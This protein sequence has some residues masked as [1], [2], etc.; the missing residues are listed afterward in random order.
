MLPRQLAPIAEWFDRYVAGFYGQDPYV[1]A[2]LRYKE[3]HCRH[4]RALMLDLARQLDQQA[5]VQALAEAI[6]L[7]HDVGRFEQFATYRTYRDSQSVDH[8]ALG[9]EVLQ[10]HRVLAPLDPSEQD[11]AEAAIRLHAVRDL[12]EGLP[13]ERLLLA[14]MVRDCDKLDIYRIVTG[15]YRD[16]HQDPAHH[17]LG[18]RFPDEPSC[19]RRC[20]RRL[21][22]VGPLGLTGCGRSMTSNSCNSGGS[23]TS[24]SAQP[25]APSRIG[26]IWSNWLRPFQISTACARPNRPCSIT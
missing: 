2:N 22:R 20:S 24:T 17:D 23:T 14:Q 12:P 3:C 9:V 4:V 26:G 18:V 1:N 10:R 13:G 15:A 8:A 5:G 21:W 6:G 25:F 16:Y 7:L 11:L 19:T